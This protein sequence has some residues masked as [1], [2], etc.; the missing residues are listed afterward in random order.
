MNDQIEYS[1]L[2]SLLTKNGN[3]NAAITRQAWFK[4]SN[5]YKSILK[6]TKC[7]DIFEH[8]TFAARFQ[9]LNEQ[10]KLSFCNKCNEPY[11]RF[12]KL[13]KSYSLC[14]HR[15]HFDKNALVK[16]RNSTRQ[17]LVEQ[18][19]K[20]QEEKCLHLPDNDFQTTLKLLHS[21][22]ANFQF[23]ISK[24]LADFY[25]DLIMKTS[26][27]ISFDKDHLRIPERLYLCYHK[28]HE[29]PMCSFCNKQKRTFK[30]RIAG[31]ADSC[32]DIHCKQQVT[33]NKLQKK[34]LA[35][36]RIYKNAIDLAVDF[37][38]FTI[39]EYPK[40]ISIDPLK[41]ECKKC[42]RISEF[43]FP[44]GRLQMISKDQLYCKFCDT[45]T[46]I[47]ECQLRKFLVDEC[48]MPIEDLLFNDRTIIAPN[49]L[50]VFIESRKLAIEFDGIF[51]HS[52]RNDEKI[53]YHLNK[54]RL[55][56]EKGIQLVHVFENEWRMKKDIVKSKLRHLLGIHKQTIYARSCYVKQIESSESMKFQEQTHIQGCIGAN[57]HL[58]LFY[59]DELVS[60]MTFGKP[61][62]SKKCEWEIL[63]F[64]TKLNCQVVGGAS[65][66]LNYFEKNQHPMSIIT[67]ADRRWSQ[68]K[69]YKA[70]GFQ[71]DHTSKP[72]YWYY[73]NNLLE[74]RFK[75]QKHMLRNKFAKFDEGK[76]EVDN[77]YD[78]G[79]IRIFDCGSLVFMKTF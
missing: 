11:V 48:N 41:L 49:E 27:L 60:V 24:D 8:I 59:E 74:S 40:L 62:F 57:V 35:N 69:L 21:K 14:S 26:S 39:I 52:S 29:I 79:Y 32:D 9:F 55:C 23:M 68:G 6:Q 44:N 5:I 33:Q 61:R 67:Y 45:R 70:L 42:H 75:Y 72:D 43:N 53:N 13:Q 77:M 54:T 64:S 31:Y 34:V 66:L 46:S 25:S 4:T 36:E 16:N 73:K 71:L 50:D 56:E 12:P 2:S 28:M 78:N 76:S 3:L 22:S 19:A 47:E 10:M 37:S 18:I 30:N 65:K 7:L 63:R 15:Q 20:N 51:W 17:Q 58:G 38:K 1:S